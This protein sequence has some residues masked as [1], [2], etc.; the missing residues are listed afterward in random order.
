M[1][2]KKDKRPANEHERSVLH[3][4]I[5]GKQ[6]EWHQQYIT[7]ADIR[8]L[9]SIPR[10]EEILLEVKKPWEDEWIPD[11]KQVNLARPEIERFYSKDN[12]YNIVVDRQH[13]RVRQECMTGKEILI[14]AG[15][16]P[17]ERF[18]L[19]QRFK[20]GKVLKVGYEQN[21]CFSDPGIEKFMTIPLDQTEG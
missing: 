21:V 16:N 9:G 7:G 10:E 3:L 8:R 18:Q 20:G 5:N 15:K 11:D 2:E 17:P 12:Y 13:F 6:Y 4:T 19:N 14:L 1:E